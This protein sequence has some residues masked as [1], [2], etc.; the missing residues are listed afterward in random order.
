[1][2]RSKRR[3]ARV[4]MT[5][6]YIV[7]ELSLWLGQLQTHAPGEE[8]ACELARLRHEAEACPSRL[9]ASSGLLVE[10]SGGNRRTHAGSGDPSNMSN[11]F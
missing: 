7:G 1:M 3:A 2:R 10:D 5:Q 4:E 6:Q 11:P 9:A 8:A